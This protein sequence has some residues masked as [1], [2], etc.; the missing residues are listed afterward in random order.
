[1]KTE[2]LQMDYIHL[3]DLEFYGFHGALPE[4]TKLGQIFKVTVTLACD[5]KK[6]GETD[7]LD[8]TVNYAEVFEL[9]KEIE[10][11][12][13]YLLIPKNTNFL[14]RTFS[15]TSCSPFNLTNGAAKSSIRKK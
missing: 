6:A 12:K 11:G 1:M 10:E 4:E 7:N 13:P 3:N 5:L 15:N 9:C 14:S 2:A 8:E